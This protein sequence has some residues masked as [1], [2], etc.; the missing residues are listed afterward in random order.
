MTVASLPTPDA[1]QYLGELP[2]GIE[3]LVWD[4]SGERPAGVERLEF[5]VARYDTAAPPAGA[6]EGLPNLG[7]VQLTSAGVEPWL[8]VVPPGVTLCN[9]RG[10]HG[11][12]TAELAVA[13]LLAQLRDLPGYEQARRAHVWERRSAE[14]LA[15][16]RVLIVGAGDIG[17]HVAAAVRVFGAEVTLVARTARV[18]VRSIAELPRLL[19]DHDVVVLALPHTAETHR[20]VDAAFLA[21]L[22]DGALLV[23]VARGAIVDTEAL[24]AELTAGRLRAFL[25]VT[26]PEPLPDDHP[27]WEA[28]GLLLTPHIGGGTEGWPRRA[29]GMVREQL[30]RF[31]AGEPLHNVVEHGY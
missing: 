21:A 5:F 29:Y 12:S 7:V 1:V 30:L 15:G 4:G 20:L 2:A 14:G 3:L 25:D 23:N 24:L 26:D 28:P 13:G 8:P 18:G 19:P 17:A 27:L 22:P 10:V 11:T 31:H 16:R 6:L 9:G